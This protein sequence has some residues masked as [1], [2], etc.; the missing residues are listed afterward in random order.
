M[1]YLATLGQLPA[2]VPRSDDG[3]T[4]ALH[5]LS[6]EIASARESGDM[7]AE[8]HYRGEFQR[9]SNLHAQWIAGQAISD[10]ALTIRDYVPSLPAFT[11]GAGMLLPVVALAAL[12]MSPGGLK[13]F[14]GG[15]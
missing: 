12:A 7:R 1:A 6:A 11:F 9:M 5:A 4:K 15:R 10:T 8:L 2:V 14:T 13:R 3:F